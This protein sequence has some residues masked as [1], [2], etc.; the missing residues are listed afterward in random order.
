M[1]RQPPPTTKGERY[2]VV[3]LDRDHVRAILDHTSPTSSS[4][5]RLRAFAALAY[6]TG[7]RHAELLALRPGDI[8]LDRCRVF[9]R[10]GKGDK[11]R[12]AVIER[13]DIDA[14]ELA[15]RWLDR[16]KQL[17]L[18]ARHPVFAAYTVGKVGKPLHQSYIR[19]SIKRAAERAGIG[20]RVHPHA[21]RHTH[22]YGLDRRGVSPNTIR[23]QLGH[24]SLAVTGR[25]LDHLDID[26]MAAE[27]N[28]A[29]ANH[30]E[31]D[32]Q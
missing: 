3:V 31:G 14:C 29:D 10:H 27:I 13:S 7:L 32:D 8:D 28:G 15:R 4:G 22:A 19:A 23:K 21:L 24:S 16:R 20:H 17:G 6:A 18:T 9:V 12:T 2:P 11:A 5:L 1:P 25:Y 30:H 26:S